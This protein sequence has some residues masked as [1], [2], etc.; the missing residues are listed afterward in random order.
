MDELQYKYIPFCRFSV[1]RAAASIAAI[2][3]TTF[4]VATE[5]HLRRDEPAQTVVLPREGLETAIQLSCG[6]RAGQNVCIPVVFGVPTA[7][8]SIVADSGME[9]FWIWTL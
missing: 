7:D 4:D 5:L 1:W 3:R 2:Q 8:R 9:I 6:E